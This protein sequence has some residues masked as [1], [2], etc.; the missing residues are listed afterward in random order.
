MVFINSIFN[1]TAC[2]TTQVKLQM[3]KKSMGRTLTFFN[4]EKNL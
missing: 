1:A 2:Q 4:S 3:K